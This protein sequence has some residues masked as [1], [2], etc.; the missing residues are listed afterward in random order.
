MTTPQ[1]PLSV[2]PG[3]DRTNATMGTI[4]GIVGLILAFTVPPMGILLGGLAR[5]M[6]KPEKSPVATAA[7]IIG[8]IMTVLT[9]LAIV[10][11]WLFLWWATTTA[12]CIGGPPTDQLFGIPFCT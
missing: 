2:G 12:M 7:I 5:A 1:P 9:V 6:A 4:L 10:A 11:F 8:I 3:A